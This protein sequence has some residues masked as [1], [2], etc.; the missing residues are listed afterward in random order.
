MNGPATAG[1]AAATPGA[2]APGAAP[3]ASA[4]PPSPN[5]RP[6]AA[7]SAA[8]VHSRS[9]AIFF[10]AETPHLFCIVPPHCDSQRLDGGSHGAISGQPLGLAEQPAL[11]GD[12]HAA[13][14]TQCAQ[15]C[16]ERQW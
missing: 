12:D 15:Q 16:T 4:A 10:I 13:D 3:C 6:Q 5:G 14:R 8:C 2:T 9:H 1:A 11:L 7:T